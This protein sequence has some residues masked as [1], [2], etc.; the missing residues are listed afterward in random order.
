[1]RSNRNTGY[2][3][4]ICHTIDPDRDNAEFP[5]SA[6][7]TIFRAQMS[8]LALFN[9]VFLGKILNAVYRAEEIDVNDEDVIRN[10]AVTHIINIC[11]I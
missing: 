7:S 10:C 3:D 1:M 9:Q 5:R 8:W 2:I 11:C 6:Y 4:P